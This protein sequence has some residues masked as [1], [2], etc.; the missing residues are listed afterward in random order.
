MNNLETIRIFQPYKISIIIV[1][2]S[3]KSNY[4]IEKLK[5]I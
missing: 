4:F 2:K 5:I 3:N 1:T